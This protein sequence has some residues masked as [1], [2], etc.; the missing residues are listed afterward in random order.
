MVAKTVFFS[1]ENILGLKF[2]SCCHA[3]SR[4]HLD[5]LSLLNQFFPTFAHQSQPD[6]ET[7]N[8]HTSQ[9]DKKKPS[10]LRRLNSIYHFRMSNDETMKPI[11]DFRLNLMHLILAIIGISL[12]LIILT[13]FIIAFT[14]LREYIPGYADINLNRQVY[15]LN[16]RADSLA[17]EMQKRDVYFS[18]L[19]MVIEGYDFAADSCH[20]ELNIYEPLPKSAVDAVQLKK[21]RQ[22]SLLRAEFEAESEYDLFDT[23]TA[24][25]KKSGVMNFFVPLS[26][27]V[28][29][30]Y[31][32]DNGHYGVDVVAG[33]NRI[34]N[35]TLDGTVVFS[36]WSV[37]DGY[38]I[39][40][41]H[42]NGY[43]STYRHTATL[44]KK[45]G[46]YVRAG[47]AIAILGESGNEGD[48]VYLHFELWHS[49]M[50]LNPAEYMS[51]SARY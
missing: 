31:D 22:D 36:F 23:P 2:L 12:F 32:P 38:C 50:A 11:A 1:K 33:Q 51:F 7:E 13:T 37:S 4:V 27:N 42:D 49:G 39:G 45:E 46:M 18:N 30:A 29:R 43:F 34:V 20:E 25:E 10:L 44:L 9:E 5:P 8:N 3:H 48:E 14:P 41:Q 28:I 47:E 15:L 17:F 40:L 6:M 26:G 35:A 16:R 19:Q 21:S 24:P